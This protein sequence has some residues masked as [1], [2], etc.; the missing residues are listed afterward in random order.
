MPWEQVVD[1]LAVV[2]DIVLVVG[3]AGEAGAVL[4]RVDEV[5]LEAVAAVGLH[6][7]FDRVIGVLAHRRA[8]G[9]KEVVRFVG[10]CGLETMLLYEGHVG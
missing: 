8:A 9:T 7:V 10:V 6:Q 4:Q 3:G 5:D 2:G 1:G